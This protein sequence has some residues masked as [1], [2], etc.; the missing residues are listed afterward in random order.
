MNAVFL[1]GWVKKASLINYVVESQLRG[2]LTDASFAF[3][4]GSVPKV[5][6]FQIYSHFKL[7]Y[8]I[9]FI[10]KLSFLKLLK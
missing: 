3:S 7:D 5:Y 8:S 9:M 10:S 1:L 6:S 4:S 2:I